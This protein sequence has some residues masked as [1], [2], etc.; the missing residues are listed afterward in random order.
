[1]YLESTRTRQMGH[2]LV[3]HYLHRTADDVRR[4][5]RPWAAPIFAREI[6]ADGNENAPM[7]VYLQGGPGF[8]SPRPQQ[9]A[10]WLAA[11]LPRY[12]VLLLD[13]RGTGRSGALLGDSAP[14]VEE[15]VN[16]RADGIVADC[17]DF[18]AALGIDRWNLFGQSFGG[19]C[20]TTY[21]SLAPDAVERVMLT[22]GLPAVGRSADE[23]YRATYSTLRRRH[24][25][26]NAQFPAARQTIEDVI[27]HLDGEEEILPTGER[28]S[29][30]RFRTIGIALGRGTGFLD[31]AYL[32]EDPFT[33]RGGSRRLRADFL[34]DV[35]QRV[36]FAHNPLYAV[37]HEA[38]YADAGCG[39]GGATAWA[40][41]RVREE[42]ECF[43]ENGG[44]FLTGEHIYPWMFD[45]D[46]ALVP[47]KAQ[48]EALAAKDDWG[49]LYDVESLR[50]AT[51]TA[52]AAVYVDDI[53][54]PMDYS[55]HTASLYRD[56]RTYVTN[57]FQHNGIAIDGG[58]ILRHLMGL[59]DERD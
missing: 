14:T 17:E 49:V 33:T 43:D 5:A 10:G 19:F 46:P 24:E 25:A 2:T 29:S 36:S 45:E 40:A 47:L 1:M 48:A 18:R 27:R 4:M 21:L 53:F 38:I 26:F 57:E 23:I 39:L 11:L 54:V 20:I 15:L 6:I 32:L 58:R 41:H 37:L 42:F 35:G 51:A 59:L 50:E 28:L 7:V 55:L 12:R 52:A 8:A 3:E 16:C 44:T 9:I 56:C 22:G 34:V 13:Q 30:R 31:L